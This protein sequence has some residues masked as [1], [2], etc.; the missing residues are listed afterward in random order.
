MTD[1]EVQAARDALAARIT[2]LAQAFESQTG[3]Q[4]QSLPVF[5]AQYVGAYQGIKED[6]PGMAGKVIQLHIPVQIKVKAPR[7]RAGTGQSE[8]AKQ[9]GIE[10][11]INDG[12]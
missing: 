4:I 11:E 12:R 2:Q 9:D 8:R 1:A 3:C 7:F 10:G 5:E 6:D